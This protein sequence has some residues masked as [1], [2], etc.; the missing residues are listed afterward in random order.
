MSDLTPMSFRFTEDV[1]NKIKWTAKVN[2]VKPVQLLTQLLEEQFTKD[3]D[4]K[5]QEIITGRSVNPVEELVELLE[6]NFISKEYFLYSMPI[7]PKLRNLVLE[8][9]K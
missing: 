9:L 5:L 2:K 4:T 6:L 1:R 3:L 8:K 7:P